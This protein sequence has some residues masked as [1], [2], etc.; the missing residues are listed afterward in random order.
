MD[1]TCFLFAVSC[2]HRYWH[3]N[4]TVMSQLAQWQ[5]PN[6]VEISCLRIWSQTWILLLM[7]ECVWCSFK[8]LIQTKFR[9]HYSHI[10]PTG[11]KPIL[12]LN[13]QGLNSISGKTSYRKILRS[14]KDARFRL[15]IVNRSE[16]WQPPRQ[17]CCW[18]ACQFSEQYDHHN[19]QS[20]GFETS[21]ELVVRCGTTLSEY[22]RHSFELKSN[23]G[24]LYWSKEACA[25][26]IA[27]KCSKARPSS[28]CLLQLSPYHGIIC[29]QGPIN[30]FS[31]DSRVNPTC[32]SSLK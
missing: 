11:F 30:V 6:L 3:H 1:A 29:I 18:D 32:F 13:T 8:S 2:C 24:L 28:W 31:M 5:T 4:S 27:P 19:I 22:L 23:L 9:R 25:I 14:L 7:T 26:E 17:Q 21:Q 10:R 16:I 15:D 12:V 20:R